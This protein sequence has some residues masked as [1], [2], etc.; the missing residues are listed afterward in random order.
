M[1][2]A[3]VNPARGRAIAAAKIGRIG[4]RLR[5]MDL[6]EALAVF[7]YL[8]DHPQTA[9]TPDLRRLRQ[10]AWETVCRGA[11]LRIDAELAALSVT[12]GERN[13]G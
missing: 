2:V 9:M 4:E 5:K 1:K 3:N 7:L 6:D 11:K 8:K 10:R 12:N 13:D